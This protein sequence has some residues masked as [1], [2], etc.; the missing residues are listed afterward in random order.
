MRGGRN[1]FV[2]EAKSFEI[3]IEE[4]F[5]KLKRVI[6]EKGRCCTSWI[7]FGEISLRCL[8]EGTEAYCR[9]EESSICNKLW[10]EKGRVY[11]LERHANRIGRFIFVSIC[12]VKEKRFNLVFLERK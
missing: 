12:D 5:G 11:K 2:V 8:L 9:E 6:V 4:V 7:K 3:S 10:N 1:W